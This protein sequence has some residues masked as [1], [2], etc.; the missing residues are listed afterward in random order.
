MK[1]HYF[2]RSPNSRKVESL[3]GY[4]GL[5]PE[6]AF[7]DLMQGAQR[8]EAFLAL[9]PNGK[10]PVLEDGDFVLWESHAILVYLATLHPDKALLPGDARGRA[11]VERWMSW[12]LAHFSPNVSKVLMERVFK[13]LRG[14]TPDENAIAEGTAAFES[15]ATI[16]DRHLATRE[17][18][19]GGLT[20]ADFSVGPSAETAPLAG[21]SYD[22]YPAIARW[23]ERLKKLPGWVSPP[24]LG[25]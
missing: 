22:N 9:N 21:L 20:I 17:F 8:S 3:I 13:K 7:I 10:I 11:E 19:C 2:T 12:L 6:R 23:L 24:A 1:L 5:N 14:G 4:L 25:R 15:A 16:L 18:L